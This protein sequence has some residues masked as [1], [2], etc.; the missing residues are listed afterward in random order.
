VRETRDLPWSLLSH[1]GGSLLKKSLDGLREQAYGTR[2][3]SA[4]RKPPLTM[5]G[6]PKARCLECSSVVCLEA[7]VP[8]DHF[9]R[10]L[11]GT[12]DLSFIRKSV[13]D[14]YAARGRSCIDPVVFFKLQLLTFFEGIR[15]KRRL[16]ETALL[17][18]AHRWYVGYNLDEPLRDH[19]SLTP[20][21]HGSGECRQRPAS[22]ALSVVAQESKAQR[23]GGPPPQSRP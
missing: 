2:L 17:N 9:N 5:L 8:T 12:L 1:E 15:S 11:E 14:L 19:S 20:S 13:A 4:A 16:V 23:L 3:A 18:L 21:P 22:Q 10:H 6:P 7:L